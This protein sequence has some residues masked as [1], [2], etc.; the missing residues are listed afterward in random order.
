MTQIIL[1][2]GIDNIQMGVLMGLFDSWNLNAEIT[3]EKV[4]EKHY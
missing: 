1:K 3:D 4:S 2:G